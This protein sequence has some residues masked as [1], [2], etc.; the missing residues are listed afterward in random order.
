MRG[1]I[2]D[3]IRF[4]LFLKYASTELINIDKADVCINNKDAVIKIDS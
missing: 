2:I 4:I 1:A 3:D